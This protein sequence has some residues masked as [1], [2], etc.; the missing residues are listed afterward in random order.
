MLSILFSDKNNAHTSLEEIGEF[1][2]IAHLT[3]T[4]A[5]K[6]K[7]SVQGIG[8]D[9]AILSFKDQNTVISTDLLVEGIHFN[10]SYMPLKHLGYKAIMVNLSDI[11]AMN[12][13]ATQVTVSI[14]VSNRFGVEALE[15]LYNGIHLACKT[16]GVDLVGGDTTSSNSGLVISVT[17]IGT[18]A[19][20]KAV[21]RSG[22][23]P[24]D[25][26]VVS[27]DLGGAYLGFLIMERER[28]VFEVNPH[29]QPDLSEYTYIVERQLKPEA[30][31]DIITLLA[32]L[33]VLPT[34]MIDISD[35][36]SSEAL[37]L[38][39]NSGLGCKIYEDKLPLDPCTITTSE[40]LSMHPA[41]VALNGGEDYEL[42]FSIAQKDYDKIRGNPNLTIIGH[43]TGEHE[44]ACFITKGNEQIELTA[45]GWNAFKNKSDKS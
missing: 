35:G 45:Q 1:G 7:S 24:N 26:M 13:Q 38:C 6:Q 3:K 43:F 4:V 11:Y 2:L 12:A 16:Y 23:K 41:T 37:H 27:G 10:L 15:E 29:V 19:P 39:K 9:A 22:A 31:K 8:D 36:L 33:D 30:R 5:L 20:E 21:L 17:A 40:E 32:Q 44:Q 42:L 34:S 18:V 28:Q 25:L 14:A